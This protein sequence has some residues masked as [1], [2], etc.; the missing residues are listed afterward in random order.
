M[1]NPDIRP[2]GLP[3]NART[4]Y[5]FDRIVGTLAHLAVISWFLCLLAW[6]WK[7]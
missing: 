1:F 7:L 5:G 6:L 2:Y 3:R 4:N